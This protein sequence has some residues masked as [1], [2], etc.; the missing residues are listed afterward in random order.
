MLPTILNFSLVGL[1][2]VTAAGRNHVLNQLPPCKSV[3]GDHLIKVSVNFW[4]KHRR[5]GY[6]GLSL[7]LNASNFYV[8]KVSSSMPGQVKESL[9]YKPDTFETNWPEN[10][11][12]L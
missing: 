3:G 5:E 12:S 11:N 4:V 2:S 9:K 6:L 1:Y 8:N 7:C 10:K